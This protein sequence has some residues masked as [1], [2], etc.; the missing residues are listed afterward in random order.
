MTKSKAY[1][2]GKSYGRAYYKTAGGGF[3]CGFVFDGKLVFIGNFI[4]SRE[5]QLWFALMNRELGSFSR[6]YAVGGKCPASWYSHFLGNHLYKCYYG[7]LDR[8]FA[9]YNRDYHRAFS[10]DLRQYQRLRRGWRGARLHP[11]LKAA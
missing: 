5:G 7:F 4:H 9:R 3:E 2:Y 8:L 10:R 11:A 1:R 6:K